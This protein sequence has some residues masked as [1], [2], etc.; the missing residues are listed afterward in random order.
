MDIVEITYDGTD[1]NAEKLIGQ[2]VFDRAGD[3]VSKTEI[4]PRKLYFNAE[5]SGNIVNLNGGVVYSYFF[6]DDTTDD[7]SEDNPDEYSNDHAYM[8]QAVSD[9]VAGKSLVNLY[10]PLAASTEVDPSSDSM[11]S[12]YLNITH[13]WVNNNTGISEALDTA[14]IDYSTTTKFFASLT[15]WKQ[16]NP[17]NIVL[18]NLLFVLNL[19]NPIAY[20][21][22]TGFIAN[23]TN[24][25]DEY[26]AI[27][28]PDAINFNKTPE[29]ISDIVVTFY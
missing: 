24:V 5:K 26:T 23:G 25:T 12:Q 7:V 15:Q 29:E 28:D 4:F 19:N 13:E 9:V 18:D 1:S 6:D 2:L 17:T 10:F 27:G 8:F 14:G 3:D 11:S 20:D 22:S 21:G 16:E